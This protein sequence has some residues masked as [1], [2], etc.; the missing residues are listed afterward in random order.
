MRLAAYL[1]GFTQRDTVRH[2][3]YMLPYAALQ[4]ENYCSVLPVFRPD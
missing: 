1:L 4:Y 2:K 3:S